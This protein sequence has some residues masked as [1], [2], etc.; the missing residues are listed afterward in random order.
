VSDRERTCTQIGITDLI[1]VLQWE[2]F[3]TKYRECKILH[4]LHLQLLA[5]RNRHRL[6]FY[7]C[8]TAV[9]LVLVIIIIIILIV[10]I[11]IDDNDF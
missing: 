2:K 5:V 4:Y 11:I 7:V 6:V 1:L 10:I 8:N 3:S 9:M